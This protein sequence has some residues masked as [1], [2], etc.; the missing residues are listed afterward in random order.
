MA[1]VKRLKPEQILGRIS[2]IFQ[3]QSLVDVLPALMQTVE[4]AANTASTNS[5]TAT[6]VQQ[7]LKTILIRLEANMP[8]VV[9]PNEPVQ[10]ALDLVAP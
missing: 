5:I 2:A 1:K 4:G 10:A 6:Y 3:G 9:D 7:H 8:K